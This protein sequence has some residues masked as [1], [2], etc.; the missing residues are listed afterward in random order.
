MT[1]KINSGAF[2]PGA[3][4]LENSEGQL[5]GPFQIDS[6]DDLCTKYQMYR[7]WLL[8]PVSESTTLMV[9]SRTTYEVD[10]VADHE[11]KTKRRKKS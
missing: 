8:Y 10:T 4:I 7:P 5:Y 6:V 11:L 2:K 1:A 9:R 3:Y